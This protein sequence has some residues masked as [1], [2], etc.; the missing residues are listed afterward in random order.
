MATNPMSPDDLEQLTVGPDTPIMEAVEVLN[1]AHKRIVLVT[2]GGARLLGVITDSDVRH[3]VLDQQS[4]AAPVSAIMVT[5]PVT[6]PPDMSN[7]EV[8]SIME[9]THCYQVPVVD[10][11]GTVVDVCF[12]NELLTTDLDKDG[13]AVVMAGGL[14]ERLRPLTETTPKPLLKVGD[15]PVLFNVLERLLEAG[16]GRVVL[17]LNYKADMIRDA[18][19]A[20]AHFADRVEFVEEDEPLGTAG[21]LTLLREM[22]TRP[23]L[24][25]NG[26]LL[27]EVALAEL[28]RFHAQEQSVLTVALKQES[29]SVPFGVIDLDG[30][31]ITAL[32]EKPSLAYFINAGVYMVEPM[33][34]GRIPRGRRW[35]M[36]DVI[37]DLLKARLRV[38]G[39]PIH[40]Y[41]LDIGEHDQLT[42]AEA[43]FGTRR[44]GTEQPG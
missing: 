33:V 15:R 32:R 35:D 30:P 43:E 17:C 8:L 11:R 18:V 34:L 3:A 6:V 13:L 24:V 44:R 12:I 25:M 1:R 7:A 40:E 42:R 2:D 9:Q 19:S 38:A 23:F 21:A 37:Q 29:H 5:N 14:G 22:P 26:D 4:F 16:Y 27:T 20:Q 39:F 10:S 31:R 28:R 41:W 36:T